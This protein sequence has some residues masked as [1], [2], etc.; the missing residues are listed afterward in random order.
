VRHI[1]ERGRAYAGAG[2]DGLFVPGVA[3]P[4]TLA[5]FVR[6]VA[7][8][9]NAMLLDLDMQLEP[10]RRAGVAR[11]SF[12]PAPYLLAMTALRATA[13]KVVSPTQV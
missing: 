4:E 11:I 13:Q 9:V 1:V 3:D 5:E 2:A 10:Y 8:P 12:G 6:Q 7:L